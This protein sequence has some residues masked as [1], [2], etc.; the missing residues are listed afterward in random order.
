MTPGQFRAAL[1]TLGLSQERAAL[2]F[3]ESGNPRTVARWVAGKSAIPRA[4]AILI[5]LMLKGDKTVDQLQS[6]APP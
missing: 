3:L 5:A 6:L 2:L 4:I 1:K